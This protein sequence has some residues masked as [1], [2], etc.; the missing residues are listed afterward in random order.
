MNIRTLIRHAT[1]AALFAAI[2]LATASS[3]TATPVP[4]VATAQTQRIVNLQ[5]KGSAEI[6]RRV[7][8]LNAAL[9]KLSAGTKLSAANKAALAKQIQD[10]LTGLAGLKAKLAADTTLAT[11]RAD[12]ASIVTDYRVYVLMLPKARLVATDDRF[13]VAE[14]RLNTLATKLQAAI[15]ARKAK[16]KDVTAL[17]TSLDDMKAK[18]ASAQSKTTGLADK[19]L[20]LSPS[21]YNANHASLI[22]YR[23]ALKGSQAG[24]KTARDDAQSIIT[25]LKNLK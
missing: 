10:E 9:A 15:T 19:L 18:I 6:D 13:G 8:N 2:P 5:T 24:L 3:M 12:V 21:D 17:Q 20:A 14:D 23:D 11:A 22:A 4:A 25:A 16:G 1:A 7:A